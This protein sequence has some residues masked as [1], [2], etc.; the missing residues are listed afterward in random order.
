MVDPILLSTTFSLTR[1]VGFGHIAPSQ[2]RPASL[3]ERGVIRVKA[4]VTKR[5]APPVKPGLYARTF[6]A[7]GP[8]VTFEFLVEL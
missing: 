2:K 6:L 1:V 5:G 7:G 8:E 4:C 3:G